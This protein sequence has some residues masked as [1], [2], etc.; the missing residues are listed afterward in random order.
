[1]NKTLTEK[2]INAIFTLAIYHFCDVC[3]KGKKAQKFL[4][5]EGLGPFDSDMFESP[6]DQEK[7]YA[8]WAREQYAEI[9]EEHVAEHWPEE[10]AWTHDYWG[11]RG[12]FKNPGWAAPKYGGHYVGDSCGFMAWFSS[13]QAL[14]EY[15]K[16]ALKEEGLR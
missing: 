5:K 14:N 11:A 16:D 4:M 10:W 6:E 8:D 9:I 1:M 7:E 2:Q 15:T 12:L 3:Y 13:L